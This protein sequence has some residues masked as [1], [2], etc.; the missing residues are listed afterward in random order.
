MSWGWGAA[1]QGIRF[2]ALE[3]SEDSARVL[4]ADEGQQRVG[5]LLTSTP[6]PGLVRLGRSSPS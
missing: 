3:R 4:L 5:T 1:E 2:Y 6:R